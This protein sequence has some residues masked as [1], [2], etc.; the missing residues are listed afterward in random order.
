MPRA[1]IVE[2]TLEKSF[3]LQE[4]PDKS[5]AVGIWRSSEPRL[6][7]VILAKIHRIFSVLI[8]IRPGIHARF[9]VALSANHRS[10]R[11]P[12]AAADE[13]SERPLNPA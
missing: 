9:T 3:K 12:L 8:S 5:L 4:K 13:I 7:F 1:A 2:E 10:R 6:G 11:P